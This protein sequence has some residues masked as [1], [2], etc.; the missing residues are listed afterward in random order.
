MARKI[1]LMVLFGGRS[2]E[3][4]VSL[5]S[6]RSILAVIDPA[7]YEVIPVGITHEGDWLTGEDT[8]AAF[9]AGKTNGLSR[10]TLLPYPGSQV[11]YALRENGLEPLANIDA[12]FPVLHGSYG[13]DGTIQGLL[14]LADLPYV[15]AGVL[16][17]SLGMDKGVFKDIM[18]MAGV[19]VLPALVASRAELQKDIPAVIARAEAAF[20]YPI[21]TKPANL[22]SSVGVTK[23]RTRSDLM[24][25]LMD[26]ARFDR[27]VLVE[28]GLEKPRE[29]EL[30][31]LGNDDLI[32][33]LPGE[34]VPSDDFYTYRAKY[35]DDSSELIV[36]APVSEEQT[37]QMQQIAIR[38]FQAIDGAGMARVDF[39]LDRATE[40]LYVSEINTIPGFTRI[41][42]YP[43]VMAASGIPY[44]ELVDRLINLALE[45][46]ADRDR[47]EHH[48]GRAS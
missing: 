2:G 8:L 39:L 6:A 26:A 5:N 12:V 20:P 28:Q 9:F 43:K 15:G 10:V 34:I 18:R 14:E 4:E 25:G 27:R 30:G 31:V 46:K 11:L 16:G 40:K 29:I 36:P 22:G 45:R 47:T 37:A 48:Y 13:E 21:F 35:L 24:E 23:C 32:A 41:S 19:P 1:N 33:S 17:S 44:P 38:A 7:K 42:M 3:H